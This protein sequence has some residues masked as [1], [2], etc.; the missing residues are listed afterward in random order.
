MH[1]EFHL[2]TTDQLTLY[3]QY[4]SH[5]DDPK[6]VI[7]LVHGMGE[8]SSRYEHVAAFMN[9]GGYAVVAMDHRGHGKSQGKKGHTPSYNNLL[10]DIDSLIKK[11]NELFPG[12]PVFLYGHSMGGNLVLNYGIRRQPAGIRGIIATDP[13]LT[14]AFEPPAWKVSLGKTFAGIFPGL[15]QATGLDTKALSRDPEVVKKYENDPL[16]HDKMTARF[17]V[18]VHF[19]G[20]YAIE[21]AAELKLPA[22]IM[23]GTGDKITSFK[24][25]E[26]FARKAHPNVQLKLWEGLYHE[27]HNEPEKDEV[28][29]YTLNWLNKHI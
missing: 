28:M 12:K 21:H 18:E 25:S 10:D 8:H 24:G 11:A 27:I 3:G 29:Q 23:H 2:T 20:P 14:L 5:G 26:E 13:Y 1:Q 7:C 4:W 15:S 17:F 19:A 9:A 16:V 6:A 22:L